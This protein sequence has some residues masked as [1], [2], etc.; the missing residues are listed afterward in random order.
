MILYLL[1]YELEFLLEK[2]AVFILKNNDQ[3]LCIVYTVYIV[4]PTYKDCK[5]NCNEKYMS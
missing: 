5:E 2:A 1:S 3:F 4:N